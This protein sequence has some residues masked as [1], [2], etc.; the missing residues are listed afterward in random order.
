MHFPSLTLPIFVCVSVVDCIMSPW[1]AW[2]TCSV[3]CGLGSLFRQ[4]D[5]IR[6]AL[7][8][9]ACGG[10]QFDSR[11]CFPKACPVHGLWS[12]WTEWSE[13]DAECG[14]GVRQRNR[15]CSAPPP[16]NDGRDCEGTAFRQTLTI[17]LPSS[18]CAV[19]PDG[20][21]S[22]WTSWSECS[23]TCFN[24]V[25]DVGIKQRFRSCNHTLSLSS[26]IH[27]H[28]LCDG[29]TDFCFMLPVHGG[30]SAWSLWTECSAKCDSGVQT[31]ERFCN[32]PAPQHGGNSC[33]GP[34]IQTRDCN[35]HPL[36]CGW[37][38][39]T[40]WSACSR[41]CDVGVRRRYRSGTN[42]PLAF[43]GRPCKG[44]RVGIDTCSI[45]PCIGGKHLVAIVI[46]H[47]I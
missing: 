46:I 8:E 22:K 19:L 3:S 38:S 25:D 21:W 45:E 15:T 20:V 17:I 24:H 32:S 7:P 11:A 44:D 36:D 23:K 1:T 5:I 33:I 6:E 27:A 29:D 14:G 37:S 40:Q 2:S 31:R 35:S 18:C 47:R 9:G 43:G 42:P 30:W 28:S 16:K 4:R 10:A 39:W 41:T 34:H 12:E 13:C 26:N